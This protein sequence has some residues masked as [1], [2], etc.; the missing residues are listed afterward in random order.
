MTYYQ[1]F[2]KIQK[3]NNTIKS[4]I[5]PSFVLTLFYQFSYLYK[6]NKWQRSKHYFGKKRIRP[7]NAPLP[8]VSLKIGNRPISIQVRKLNQSI[9]MKLQAKS[10]KSHPNSAR[11]NNFISSKVIEINK[12]LL[13]VESEVNSKKQIA[14]IKKTISCKYKSNSFYTFAEAYFEE[15]EK[16]KKYS[17]INCER[18]LLN[19]I[20]GYPRAKTLTFEA[21]TPLFCEALSPI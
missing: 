3:S 11:L 7:G 9:G 14:E 13:D 5:K 15:L 18:P 4:H 19:R 12:T 8:S 10:K 2:K 17:R 20:K 16:N 6:K 1:V 21:I